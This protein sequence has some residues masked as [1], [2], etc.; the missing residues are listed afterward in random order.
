LEFL[1]TA[2]LEVVCGLLVWGR[3]GV[4][5]NSRF[6]GCLWFVGFWFGVWSLGFGVWGLGFGGGLGFLLT[7][8]LEV[9][10]GLLVCS[11]G[12]GV[13]ESLGFLLTAGLE[14]VCG[15]WFVVCCLGFGRVWS[16]GEVWGFC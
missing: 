9:V 2:V 7:A 13:W 8:V 11:L 4:F 10:C 15:L 6:G 12:F 5:V 16:L 3:F 1:L 14:G